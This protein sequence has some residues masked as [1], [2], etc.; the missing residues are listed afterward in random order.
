M[1]DINNHRDYCEVKNT[2]S[3]GFLHRKIAILMNAGN[4][5]AVDCVHQ[6]QALGFHIAIVGP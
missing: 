2:I 4:G 3:G 6:L 5:T 1:V